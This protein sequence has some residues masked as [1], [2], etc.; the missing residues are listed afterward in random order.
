VNHFRSASLILALAVS[1]SV[2]LVAGISGPVSGYVFDDATSQIRPIVGIPGGAVMGTAVTLPFTLKQAVISP[3]GI[4]IGVSDVGQVFVITALSADEPKLTQLVG[5]DDNP[6]LI[7]LS[8]AG[9]AA[10]LYW[11]DGAKAEVYAHLPDHPYGT[12]LDFSGI[13]GEILA[14]APDNTGSYL[15]ATATSSQNSGA[16]YRVAPGDSYTWVSTLATG[17]RPAAVQ[18]LPNGLD[19]VVVDEGADQVFLIAN[20]STA[21]EQRVLAIS[22]DGVHT[23]TVVT[24]DDDS[25]LAGTSDSPTLILIGLRDGFTSTIQAVDLPC[26]PV[27]LSQLGAPHLYLLGGSSAGPIY[28]LD[29]TQ[30]PMSYFVPGPAQ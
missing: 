24:T 16:V 30:S 8:R 9:T 11:K 2:K 5:I 6:N 13:P 15:L 1:A 23:P 14:I 26:P 3:A 20:V 10:A 28:L 27:R 7:V 25:I 19:A 22:A 12:S 18:F 17:V 21:P 4:G 29:N